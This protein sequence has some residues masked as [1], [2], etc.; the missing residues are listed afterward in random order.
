[1]TTPTFAPD[2]LSGGGDLLLGVEGSGVKTQ[3]VIADRRGSVIGRGLAGS[4]NQHRVGLD[5]AFD[6]LAI[7]IDAATAQAPPLPSSA[8]TSAWGPRIAAACLGLSGVDQPQVAQLPVVILDLLYNASHTYQTTPSDINVRAVARSPYCMAP[9]WCP[10][11]GSS[12]R[13]LSASPA[14][15]PLILLASDRNRTRMMI[16]RLGKQK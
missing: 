10:A 9:S 3:A 16:C 11:G 7:A 6:A 1:M 13:F 8:A 12:I 4:S 2:V 14:K 15:H 5:K